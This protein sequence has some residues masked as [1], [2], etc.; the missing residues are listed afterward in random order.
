MHAGQFASI[1]AVIAHYV[2]APA[3]FVGQT[4]LSQGGDGNSIRKPIRLSE[5]EVK[6][7][8]AFLGTLSGPIIEVAKR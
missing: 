8:A 5:Q 6:A 3:A 7:L 2:R 1:E 4:E